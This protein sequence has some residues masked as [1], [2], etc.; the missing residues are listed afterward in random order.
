MKK[1]THIPY[2][3]HFGAQSIGGLLESHPHVGHLCGPR[4]VHARTNKQDLTLKRGWTHSPPLAFDVLVGVGDDDEIPDLTHLKA[5]AIL[6]ALNAPV[7][8]D[9]ATVIE[10]AVDGNP[11]VDD[12]GP[13]IVIVVPVTP[14][15]GLNGLDLQRI[16]IHISVLICM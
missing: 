5:R 7:V 10:A 12:R 11:P 13:S 4:V 14:Q 2:W 8:E 3:Q 15:F 9:G 1:G 16:S 6:R